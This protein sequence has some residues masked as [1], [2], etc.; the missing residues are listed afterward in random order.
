MTVVITLEHNEARLNGTL[1]FLD[2]GPNNARFQIYGGV[3][4]SSPA[5]PASNE[6]LVEIQLTKPSGIISDGLLTLTQLEDGLISKTGI[7][8]WARLVTGN[9]INALDLDCSTTEGNGDVK[10]ASTNLYLGG[11]ARLVSAV[12]G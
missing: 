10:L 6:L 5:S 8:T 7:A 9:D 2:N 3:R 12:L 1:T 4:P 11:D